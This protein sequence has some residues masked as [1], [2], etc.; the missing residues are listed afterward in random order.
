VGGS[1]QEWHTGIDE[2]LVAASPIE[3]H[4]V[5]T[6]FG[7]EPVTIGYEVVLRTG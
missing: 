2:G 5:M 6:K 1:A 7:G 4:L 3:L